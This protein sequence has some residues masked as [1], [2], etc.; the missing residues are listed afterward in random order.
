MAGWRDV[1]TDKSICGEDALKTLPYIAQ[2]FIN[3]PEKLDTKDIELVRRGRESS[4]T[5]RE[6]PHHT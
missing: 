5:G 4:T 3:P 2:A 1:P 6:P